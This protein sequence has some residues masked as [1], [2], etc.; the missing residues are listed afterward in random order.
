MAEAEGI[1]ES[2]VGCEE[3]RKRR[4][5]RCDEA[6]D[7]G[8]YLILRGGWIAG[9][10]LVK[11][12]QLVAPAAYDLASLRGSVPGPACHWTP[13]GQRC[14]GLFPARQ[15]PGRGCHAEPIECRAD[16]A[17]VPGYMT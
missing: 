3:N 12:S 17:A 15:L 7:D 13:G 16:D 5:G 2:H 4:E 6:V 8:T 10:S 11:L 14:M 9:S 1:T